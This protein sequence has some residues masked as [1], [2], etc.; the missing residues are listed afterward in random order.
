LASLSKSEKK[1]Q[2][3]AE[4]QA[5][6]EAEKGALLQR[7]APDVG[8]RLHALP[9]TNSNP[10]LAPHLQRLVA[11][12]RTPKAHKNGS[13]FAVKVTWCTSKGD[14]VGAWS[15]KEH[16]A[17]SAMEF[18]SDIKPQMDHFTQL[19]W[20]EVDGLN[21]GTQHKMHHHHEVGDIIPEAQDRWR[22]IG[23]EEYDTLFRFRLGAKKRL[24]GFIAQGHFHAVWWDRV[25][26]IYPVHV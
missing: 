14:T 9:L 3:K 25:H 8:P 1:A 24:W 13:H 6:F 7:M 23:L 10:R 26:A 5:K 12:E 15:W 20:A 2:R 18:D 19:T 21:S 22:E 17:W 16:R 11:N 4:R